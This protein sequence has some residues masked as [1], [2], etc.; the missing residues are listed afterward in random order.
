MKMHFIINGFEES[1][2]YFIRTGSF[3]WEQIKDM[4]ENGKVYQVDVN[5]YSIELS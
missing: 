2:S 4:A 1:A 3:T 5:S